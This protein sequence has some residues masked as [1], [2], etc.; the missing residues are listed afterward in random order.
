MFRK[1]FQ[2]LEYARYFSLPMTFM[3]WLIIFAYSLS[4]SGNIFYGVLALIGICFVHL[5]TNLT[6]DFI[7]YKYMMKSLNFDKEAY[8]K[9]TQKTKCRYLISGLISE[10][11]LFGI[12]SFFMTMGSLIG[13]Y[14]FME[15]GIGILYF[16]LA[17]GII[18]ILYPFASRICLSEV[19]IALAYGPA[20]FGGVYYA[21]TGTYSTDAFIISIPSTIITVVLSYIHTVMDYE[22]DLNEGHRTIANRFDSQLDSLIVLKVFL[23]LAYIS[24]VFICIFDIAD[25]QVFLTL[26]TIPLAIDLY[27]SLEIF[28]DNPEAVQ[29]R[30][31]YHFPMENW[32]KLEER[33]ET[34]F[35]M[36][37]YQSRNL[38]IYFSLFLT[39]GIVISLLI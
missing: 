2:I 30:K 3:S 24:V 9:N 33:N 21:M 19:L 28:S 20:L 18:A 39:L 22:F 15:C 37:M 10:K 23:I 11:E 5:G 34:S 38:M 14:L 36:R 29:D 25:W 13:L 7:D 12:I 4:D 26:L 32:K 16:A 27:K 6:D 1:L 35:M 17:G 8:L 31:W